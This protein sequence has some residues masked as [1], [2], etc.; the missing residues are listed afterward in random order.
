MSS[1]QR[2][3][4]IVIHLPACVTGDQ[5]HGALQVDIGN[6][7]SVKGM[8]E[9]IK[10]VSSVPVSIVVNCA[11]T[12]AGFAS[13]IDTTEENFDKVVRVNLKVRTPLL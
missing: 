12:V 7:A 10:K 9:H 1:G 3:T 2:S 13:I 11:G 4:L 6:S 5:K 8:F